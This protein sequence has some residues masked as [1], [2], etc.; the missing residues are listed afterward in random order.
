MRERGKGN[1]ESGN[2]KK[3]AGEERRGGERREESGL[4]HI[5]HVYPPFK[6]KHSSKTPVQI[7]PSVHFMLHLSMSARKDIYFRKQVYECGFRFFNNI[8]SEN[9]HGKCT[10]PGGND[11]RQY[12]ELFD[13][14]GA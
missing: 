7:L 11:V 5:T 3:E 12:C 10:H 8:I 6:S 14:T 1:R 2:E 13:A 4:Q 9:F